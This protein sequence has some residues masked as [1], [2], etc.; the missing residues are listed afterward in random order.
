[1]V[2]LGEIDVKG[3]DAGASFPQGV[4][5]LGEV[6]AWKRPT[7]E[8]VLTFLVDRYNHHLGPRLNLPSQLEPHIESLELDVG[9]E[10]KQGTGV[11]DDI[12]RDVEA[13]TDKADRKAFQ[14]AN[15]ESPGLLE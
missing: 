11:S 14:Q 4:Y 8:H 6:A 1:L 9:Q 5:G 12:D 2:G 13:Q 3:D 7:P 15:A 10:L